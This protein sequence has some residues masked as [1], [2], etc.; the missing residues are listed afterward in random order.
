MIFACC[1]RYIECSDKL[2]CLH[3]GNEDYKDCGYRVNL[4]KGRV[5]YGK[6]AGNV[7]KFPAP[8]KEKASE[9][10][11]YCYDRVF[12]IKKLRE[13]NLSY[14]LDQENIE[15]LEEEF[16]RLQIPFRTSRNESECIIEAS[17]EEPANSRVVF[18][19]NDVKFVVLNYNC[20]LILRRH[21]VGIQKALALKG[22]LSS[23]DQVGSY[24]GVV[25]Y[26]KPFIVTK[27]KEAPPE[28]PLKAKVIQEFTQVSIFEL[29]AQK[30]SI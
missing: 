28:P 5:F 2:Q 27:P 3:V 20:Y 29:L 23:V 12:A 8:I 21:S 22:I 26:T 16:K 18:T 25:S 7:V 17:P 14:K 30:I 15:I 4:E 11:L 13:N 9:I 1:G 6:N 19:L 10:F 24:Q